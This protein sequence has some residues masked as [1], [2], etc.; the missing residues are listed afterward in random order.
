VDFVVV[1]FGLGALAVLLGLALRDRGPWFWR[2]SPWRELA[3]PLLVQRVAWGRGCRAGG[4]VL[5]LAGGAV[6]LV[7]VVALLA[8]ADDRPGLLLVAGTITL[9]AAGVLAWLLAYLRF[10][11]PDLWSPRR[12]AP[13]PVAASAFSPEPVAPSPAQTVERPWLPA[14]P[15]HVD[16]TSADAQLDQPPAA[17]S[18]PIAEPFAIVPAPDAVDTARPDP[19]IGTASAEAA[20]TPDAEPPTAADPDPIAAEA[21]AT[22]LTTAEDE[23]RRGPEAAAA[24]LT[25]N[26]AEAGADVAATESS[27]GPLPIAAKG[28]P[29]PPPDE[30]ASDRTE[31]VA[32]G[33]APGERT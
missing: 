2:V 6:L 14:A 32:I 29:A 13:T 7:T 22:S 10:A 28:L 23:P 9:A 1:G 20:P 31:P 25:A 8:G 17:F 33:R 26:A 12:P 11:H 18:Q 4:L 3:S 16:A 30:D 27:P 24:P 15:S 21:N 19:E 5:A